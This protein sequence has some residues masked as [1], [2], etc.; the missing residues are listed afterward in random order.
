MILKSERNSF[1]LTATVANR[2]HDDKLQDIIGF[3]KEMLR[4]SFFE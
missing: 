2:G 1:C 4:R 3:K